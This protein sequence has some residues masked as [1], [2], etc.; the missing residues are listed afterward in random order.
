MASRGKTLPLAG[1]AAAAHPAQV[2]R[3]SIDLAPASACVVV[4]IDAACWWSGLSP[5]GLGGGG[6]E[7]LAEQVRAGQ[8]GL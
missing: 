6:G 1:A 3:L 7:V 5:Y 8:G 2:E 4:S